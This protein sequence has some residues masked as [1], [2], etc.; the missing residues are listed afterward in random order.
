MKR[1]AQRIGLV[2]L[3]VAVGCLARAASAQQTL[4]YVD[5]VKRLTDLERLA[6]LPAAG[7][8]VRPV[9]QLR[10]RQQVRRGDRQ[11]RRLGRQRRRRRHHPQRGR[12]A[13]VMA[14][15]EGPGCIW[16]I[17]SARPKQGHVKIYLDGSEQPAVDLPF[18]DYFDG[19]HAPFTYPLLSYD[20][21]N[22]GLPRAEPLLPDPVPEVVQ[23]RGRQ[24]L[25]QLLPLHLRDLPKGTKVPTFSA[26]AAA[27]EKPRP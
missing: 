16:R 9:V 5:L 7:R 13:S 20:L 1:F 11:V 19:K 21:K 4:T 10:P 26:D 27:D 17:W 23:D 24:G 12:P 14:E 6:V 18:V 3:V 15:M 25:G 2:L 8:D 22:I